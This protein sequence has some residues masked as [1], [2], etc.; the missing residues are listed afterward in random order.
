[1]TF[2]MWSF[3]HYLFMVS[4]IILT[5]ILMIATKKQSMEQKRRLGIILSVVAIL[6]LILR[7][8][9]IWV[10]GGYAFNA[11]LVP[12]QICHFANFVLL[13]A[14][15]K[16]SKPLFGFALLLNLPAAMMSIVFANSLTNYATIL[17]FRGMAYIFGHILIVSLTLYAYFSHF[18]VLNK[19]ILKKTL[20]IV[21]TLY[22]GSVFINNLFRIIF[23]QESNY[24]YTFK[25][26]D[27][28][29]LEIFFR[30]GHNYTIFGDFQVNPL[31]LLMTAVLGFMVM[32]IVYFI[33]K[34]TSFKSKNQVA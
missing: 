32:M 11:E 1:M 12:L 14:F 22:A 19:T 31:Y 9:E 16:D 5:I 21:F 28:T 7:N 8:V 6:I 18:I 20:G 24:F 30:L 23:L 3:G 15:W 4:P 33:A 34:P 10:K 29:P 13:I 2:T 17:T 26:E 25:P 27:G